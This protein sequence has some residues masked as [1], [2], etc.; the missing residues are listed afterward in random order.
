MNYL[1]HAFLSFNQKDLLIGNLISDFVK[2]RKK[3][4]YR[5]G[6]QDGITLH[7][8]IDEFTDDHRTTRQTK[9]IF[10]PAVGAYAGAFLD[11]AYDHFL[12]NDKRFFPTAESLPA[13]CEETYAALQSEKVLPPGFTQILPFMVRYNWLF[14]Y[15]FPYGIQKSFEGLTRRAR[16]LDNQ[17]PVFELFKDNYALLGAAYSDF[18]DELYTFAQQFVDSLNHKSSP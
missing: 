6:V 11:I 16:Y 10:K 15:Q 12:A 2:G 18:F 3:F 7:R 5:Q 4:D 9:L 14:N 13:F 8:A 1:A 17:V